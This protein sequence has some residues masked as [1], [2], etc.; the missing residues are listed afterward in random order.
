M[1]RPISV[2]SKAYTFVEAIV[3]IL[4]LLV[5][6]ALSFPILYGNGKALTAHAVTDSALESR[7]LLLTQLSQFTGRVKIPYW[8]NAKKPFEQSGDTWQVSYWDGNDQE[9]LAL[10]K[11]G[12]GLVLKS[13]QSTLTI[14]HL[15]N[16]KLDWWTKDDRILGYTV[17][18]S[19]GPQ[20]TVFHAAWGAFPW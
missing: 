10:S 16:L 12:G 13:P 7:L 6:S 8:V 1:Q 19:D 18:W 4:L 9:S 3:T 14:Q 2:G 17:Q 11:R 20:T 5:F 15:P